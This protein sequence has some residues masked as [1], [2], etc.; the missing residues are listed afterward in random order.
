MSDSSSPLRLRADLDLVRT[1]EAVFV[2][3]ETTDR[4]WTDLAMAD[5]LPLLRE[6]AHTP[7]TA[8]E[9]LGARHP[10]EAVLAAF[11]MLEREGYL[12]AGPR[13][14]SGAAAVA[15][16]WE[17]CGV[18]SARAGAVRTEAT[19]TRLCRG[20]TDTFASALTQGGVTLA[21]DAEFVIVAVDDYLDDRLDAINRERLATGRPWALAKPTG[22]QVSFGPILVPGRTACW[23]CLRQRLRGHRLIEQYL[24]RAA[25]PDQLLRPVRAQLP[26]T[27]SLAGHFLALEL[28]KFLVDREHPGYEG[29]LWSLDTHTLALSPHAVARRPQC[30]RCATVDI[31]PGREPVP[32]QLNLERSATPEEAIDANRRPEE[33]LRRLRP[34]VDPVTGI[35]Q[36]LRRASVPP[37]DLVSSYHAGHNFA[38][39]SDELALLRRGLR[40]RSGGKGRTP[41]HAEASALAEAIERYCGVYDGTEIEREATAEELGSDAVDPEECLLFS[42]DQYTRRNELNQRVSLKERIGP[43]FDPTLRLRWT[44]VWSISR[45]RFRYLPST[46]CY[47]GHPEARPHRYYWAHSNGCAAGPT[48]EAAALQGLMELVE[49]DA[50]AIWWFNRIPRP[51]IDLNGCRD[52]YVAQL[53][54]YYRGIGRELWALDL[55]HDLGVPVVAAL[56]RAVGQS[57]EDLIY[58]FGAHWNPETALV[59][60]LTEVNQSLPMVYRKNGDGSTRYAMPIDGGLDWWKKITCANHPHLAPGKAAHSAP[61]RAYPEHTW[62]GAGEA[63][64]A[65]VR[66]LEQAGHEVLLLDQTRPDIGFPVV[67]TIVPGLRPF[68]RRFAPGRLFDVPVKLGWLPAPRAE[69]ELNPWT[70]YF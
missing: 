38:F 25:G 49:R 10:A 6:R 43:P 46:Y 47:Y 58:G 7:A 32:P 17:S 30:P 9:A 3:S 63:L 59:R 48:L 33:T 28:Q 18:V 54:E 11:G 42:A 14:E 66:V 22:H 57:H 53:V 44:P 61:S 68:W 31:R 36:M 52:P 5:L 29:R 8:V 26:A 51:T 35:V 12:L 40:A 23:E 21:D 56:S 15:A 39:V 34:F 65:L 55:T 20:E 67:K 62:T 50:V 60:A 70:I 41:A 27:A 45:Q 37:E 64:G 24:A 69:K 4:W 1:G 16:Y 13:E 19:L 2:R